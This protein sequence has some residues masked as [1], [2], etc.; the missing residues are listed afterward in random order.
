[1]RYPAWGRE[2]HD[3]LATLDHR[4]SR[5]LFKRPENHDPRFRFLL[6]RLFE[7]LVALRPGLAKERI[8][9]LESAVFITSAATT[10]PFHFDPEIAF[11]SQIE[12]E[13]IYHVFEP[14][15]LSEG[16]L[17]NFYVR[18]MINIGQVN[19]GKRDLTAER[20]FRL[21]PGLGLHQP[22]NAPHW[23]ATGASR[24]MSYSFVF[25]TESSRSTGRARS[26]NHRLRRLGIQPAR[27]GTHPWRDFVK[28]ETCRLARPVRKNLRRLARRVTR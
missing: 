13:K 14:D 28:A 19:L 22:Q 20:V 5:L 3:V 26:I 24:S 10:T 27:P 11:F 23:V 2:P 1:M 16:E 21:R 25:E 8:V 18:N 7:Q 4:P 15:V 12:G 6:D 9:R 17:E